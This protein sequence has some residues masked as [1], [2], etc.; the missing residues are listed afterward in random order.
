MR[1]RKGRSVPTNWKME[2]EEK[3]EEEGQAQEGRGE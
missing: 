3:K 2:G 1:R